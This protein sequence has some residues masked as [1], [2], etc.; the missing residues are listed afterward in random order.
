MRLHW[1]TA[2]ITLNKCWRTYKWWFHCRDQATFGQRCWTGFNCRLTA[3]HAVQTLDT[4]RLSVGFKVSKEIRRGHLSTQIFRSSG[5][6]GASSLP[7]LRLGIKGG[8]K[9]QFGQMESMFFLLDSR[10]NNSS[11]LNAPGHY[12]TAMDG[13]RVVLL[14][15]RRKH[16]TLRKLELTSGVWHFLLIL[17]KMLSNTQA[18]SYLNRSGRLGKELLPLLGKI[19]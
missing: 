14:L 9:G 6:A 15:R 19:R 11:P 12:L 18:L 1:I 4:K 3:L 17:L 5:I 16:V 7:G 2:G 8:D 10:K 13:K